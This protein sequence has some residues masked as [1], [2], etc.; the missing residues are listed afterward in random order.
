MKLYELSDIYKSF[1]DAMEAGEITDAEAIADTLESLDATFNDKA[2]AVACMIKGLDAEAA[3]IKA[4]AAA[5]TERAKAKA[6]R[7]EW[8]RGYL[9]N[10]MLRMGLSKIETPRVKLTFRKSEAVEILDEM[11]FIE[12]L[13]KDGNDQY[14]SYKAPTI[15]KIELKAAIKAGA[16]FIGAALVE[17]QNLQVK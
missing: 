9:S 11:A 16:E 7:A 13:Q 2:D 6:N 4:E 5:L 17:R 12:Q 15:N 3:A 1:L 14:L 10:N 8:L